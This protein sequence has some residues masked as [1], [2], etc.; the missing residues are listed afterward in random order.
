MLP[1]SRGTGVGVVFNGYGYYNSDKNMKNFV[2]VYGKTIAIV[3]VAGA[4]IY[5]SMP[6]TAFA[7]GT[8][9][10]CGNDP[11]CNNFVDKYINPLIIAL[12]AFV[13]VAAAISIIF[14]GIQYSASSDEP[15]TVTKAKQRIFSTILGLIAY[16]FL[17]AF[18]SYLVPGG[19]L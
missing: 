2:A 17:F 8:T 14:A 4:F 13:G 3:V 1:V 6:E 11:G 15:G 12:T 9:D 19:I 7:G 18:I 10:V 16:I 5:L